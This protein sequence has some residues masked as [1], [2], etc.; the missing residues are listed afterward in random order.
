LKD[1]K[2]APPEHVIKQQ[3]LAYINAEI[4]KQTGV[5]K[6]LPSLMRESLPIQVSSWSPENLMK[7]NNQNS[8][9]LIFNSPPERHI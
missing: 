4:T 6:V 8:M 3:T 1:P 7:L 5:D 2:L 9:E